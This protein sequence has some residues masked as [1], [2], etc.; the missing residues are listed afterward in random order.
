MAASLHESVEHDGGDE[1]SRDSN[2]DPRDAFIARFEAEDA[3]RVDPEDET[4]EG[5]EDEGAGSDDDESSDDSDDPD[6]DTDADPDGDD[7]ESSEES[8]EDDDADTGDDTESDDDAD[9]RDDDDDDAASEKDEDTDSDASGTKAALARHG[10]D[11][12]LED[13]P[14][15]FRGLIEKKLRSVDRAFTKAQQEATAFRTREREVAVES[16]YRAENPDLFIV[17][18]LRKGGAELFAKVNKHLTRIDPTIEGN[19]EDTVKDNEAVLNERIETRKRQA[20]QSIETA[21]RETRAIY[22]RADRVESTA[23]AECKRLGVPF[24]GTLEKLIASTIKEKPQGEW[25]NGLTEVEVKKV[26]AEYRRDH[27]ASVRAHRR[28]ASREAVRQS[29]AQRSG[30]RPTVRPPRGG[31]SPAGSREK[32]AKINWDDADSRQSAMMRSANRIL[33]SSKKR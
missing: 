11:L 31:A 16:K 2:A 7:D 27:H 21:E 15:K 13:V 12:S 14:E 33:G 3:G 28:E 29:S 26:V 32:K 1:G 23:R 25:K 6:E 24:N 9:E 5:D 20:A 10:A 8:E 17:D 4:D 30:K 18:M 19:D 22:E